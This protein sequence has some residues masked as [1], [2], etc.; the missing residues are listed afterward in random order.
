MLDNKQ[1]YNREREQQIVKEVVEQAKTTGAFQCFINLFGLRGIGKS[2]TIRWL[3]DRYCQDENILVAQLDTEL[4]QAG[5]KSLNKDVSI[6]SIHLAGQFIE[7]AELSRAK[8]HAEATVL[9]TDDMDK[10]GRETL[11]S[12]EQDALRKVFELP[13]LS[14]LVVIASSQSRLE[15]MDFSVRRRQISRKLSPF[16]EGTVKKEI[17]NSVPNYTSFAERLCRISGGFPL[18]VEQIIEYLK[19]ENPNFADVIE[20]RKLV[21]RNFDRF[22]VGYIMRDYSPIKRQTLETLAVLRRF[23]IAI[24]RAFLPVFLEK[25]YRGYSVA[26]YLGL[27]GELTEAALVQWRYD[28]RG[29]S[30]D[31]DLRSIVIEYLRACDE[32]FRDKHAEAARVNRDL[33]AGP[34]SAESRIRYAIEWLYHNTYGQ[35]KPPFCITADD[36]EEMIGSLH[37]V[38]HNLDIDRRVEIKEIFKEDLELQSML[39]DSAQQYLGNLT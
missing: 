18:S 12:L 38:T 39:D 24:M 28:R 7:L 32:K 3:R 2:F 31:E 8:S 34:E 6:T 37:T 30:I 35:N 26:D 20:E 23:D 36:L 19:N 1:L 25:P 29:Y 22:V 16:G 9:F 17:Q 10:L 15:W 33:I 5:I 11:Y 4:P 27:V 13:E 21:K 14:H